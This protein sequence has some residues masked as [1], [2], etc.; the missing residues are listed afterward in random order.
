[1]AGPDHVMPV[2]PTRE[3]GPSDG[4]DARSTGTKLDRL[5]SPVEEGG[6]YFQGESRA[7]G[8]QAAIRTAMPEVA[9]ALDFT[10]FERRTA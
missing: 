7:P 8:F 5:I 3:D 10:P 4:R 6:A 9:K 2:G 1:M